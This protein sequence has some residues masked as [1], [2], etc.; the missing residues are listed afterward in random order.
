MIKHLPD[1]HKNCVTDLINK[2]A[3]TINS[4]FNA[5]NF[6]ALFFISLYLTTLQ[7]QALRLLGNYMY[8]VKET[9]NIPDYFNLSDDRWDIL[10][11]C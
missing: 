10:K 6:T 7:T 4:I 11:D 5:V 2:K 8:S 1:I 9:D 3:N